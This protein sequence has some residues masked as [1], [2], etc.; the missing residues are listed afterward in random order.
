MD[1]NQA[2]QMI[3]WLEEEHRRDKSMLIELRQKVE[4]QMVVVNDQNKRIQDLEGRLAATQAKLTRF[5]LLEQAIQQAKDEML[6]IVQ[7]LEEDMIRYQRNHTQGRQLEQ[8]NSSRSINELKRHLEVIP[9]IQERLNILKTEDLRLGEVVLDLQARLTNHERKS[10]ALPDRISY[11]EGQRAQDVKIVSQ[12]QEDAV[13]LMRRL[14]NLSGKIELVDDISRKNEQRVTVLS[15]YRE[16][17]SKQQSLLIEDVRLKDAQRERQLQEWQVE[18]SR[19]EEEMAKQ[20]KILER[21]ARRHD[22][23]QQQ[24]IGIDSYK[25]TLNR[26][27]QQVT[28]LQRLSEERQQREL[29]E[30]VESNEQRWTKFHLERESKWHQQHSTNEEYVN[31]VKQLEQLREEDLVRVQQISRQLPGLRDEYRAKIRELWMIHERAAIFQ[32]D[33]VR[34]WYDEVSATVAGKVANT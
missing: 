11:V 23:V 16:D 25:Q 14:E 17:L 4:S 26:E 7:E 24:L 30:W 15:S 28:Q 19:F 27:Q 9:P 6:H 29:A 1:I 8:E 32:L 3:R 31:R 34:R 5:S 20:R 10:A 21:F 33:H 2:G 13:K 18:L 12:L 22:E